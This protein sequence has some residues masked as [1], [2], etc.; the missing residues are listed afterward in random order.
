MSRVFAQVGLAVIL[1]VLLVA[2]WW[3]GSAGGTNFYFPP[4]QKIMQVFDKLWV[5]D[6]I[7]VHVVPS[8]EAVG[9]G[10][11]ISIVLGIGIGVLLGLS[12]F[13][14][15]MTSPVLQFLRYLPAVALLPLAIQ[16]NLISSRF[17][18]NN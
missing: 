9:L 11:G 10:L 12:P 8:L 6:L 3:F 13:V 7:P 4:L 16:L 2:L 18:G 5:F 1:P 14:S 17:S 15:T